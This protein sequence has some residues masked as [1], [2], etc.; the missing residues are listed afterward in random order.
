MGGAGGPHPIIFLTPPPSKLMP[1]PDTGTLHLKMK[2]IQSEH[3][4]LKS[5]APFQEMIPRRKPKKIGN[6]H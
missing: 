2:P 3:P 5:E 1:P 6:F 4:P